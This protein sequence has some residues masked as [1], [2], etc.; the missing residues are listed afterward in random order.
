MG[1]MG[2]LWSGS[3]RAV[4]CHRAVRALI[5]V[6]A[7]IAA[8]ISLPAMAAQPVLAATVQVE[9]GDS[10]SS[11]AA[12]Y[13]TTVAAIA[14]ANGITNPNVVDA[15]AILQLPASSSLGTV[16]VE[17]GDTLSGIAAQYGTTADALAGAND[18]TN[19][20]LIDVGEILVVPGA[21]T[22]TAGGL[23]TAAPTT[24]VVEPGD[25]LTA[26][27]AHYGTTV[28]GLAAANGISD[29]NDISVGEVLHPPTEPV[30]VASSPVSGVSASLPTQLA[31][32]PGRLVAQP[33]FLQSAYEYGVPA[34]LLEALCWWES[35][36]QNTVVSVTGAIGI[37]QVEPA[38][39]TFVN[40]VLYPGQNL[41]VD[42]MAGNIA[43]GAAYLAY[44][45]QAAGGDENVA[46]AAYYQGLASVEQ[47][48]MLPTTSQY[49]AGI[50]AYAA[51]FDG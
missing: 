49:V 50:L 42:T 23:G 51:I 36:W 13:H 27:A 40:T 1:S 35:G 20:N 32:N 41:D 6:A 25:T 47:Q 8:G 4:S 30:I 28:A 3:P 11:I 29:P 43:I 18:I 48:G 17:P 10:L 24:I 31:A 39:A 34:D 45:L 7:G 26:I 33:D 14:A 37:C 15:G 16:T 38:T 22:S 12:E 9:Y 5:A 46:V 19:V 21:L 44:L 2:P